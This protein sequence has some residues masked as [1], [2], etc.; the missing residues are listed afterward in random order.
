MQNILPQFN[1]ITF[2]LLI[3]NI[4]SIHLVQLN[5][6]SHASFIAIIVTKDNFSSLTQGLA[7]YQ[8]EENEFKIVHWKYFYPY[9]QPYTEFSVGD[10][11]MFSGKF[12]V[13]NL[14]QY[15]TVSSTCII[16]TG[17]HEHVFE[18]DEI[19][20]ST[21]HCMFPIQVTRDPKELGDSTYF[22]ATSCQYNSITSSKNVHMKLRVFYPTNS[23]RFTYLRAN[24]SIKITR[25]FIVSGFIRRVTS[26]FTIIEVTDID[27]IS[28][29]VASLQNVQESTSS[30]ASNNR[31]VIDLIADDVDST[32]L[33]T[34]KRPRGIMSK[35]S[36]QPTNP[37]PIISEPVT[38]IPTPTPINISPE[39]VKNKKSKN[40]LS[41][42]ALNFL[43]PIVVDS[44][45]DS[46]EDAPD[47]DDNDNLEYLLQQE[48]KEV[49]KK[50]RSGRTS[51]KSKK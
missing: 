18:A 1:S 48:A 32:T 8:T 27:F 25:S 33:R 26:D 50:T 12:I 38:P 46:V 36:K 3:I 51:K 24:N 34:S 9:D 20:L 37:P 14:E 45:Q 7:K 28:T 40:K 21:P 39:T 10:I 41:D 2:N 47:D 13:E 17:D 42:L 4:L 31:S 23:P 5:M 35:S 16:A 15:I 19:P 6:P 30:S 44:T 11:V 43:E 22:D 29:N 49:H